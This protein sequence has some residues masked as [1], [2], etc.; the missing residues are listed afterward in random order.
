MAI[1]SSAPSS[2]DAGRIDSVPASATDADEPD[3]VRLRRRAIGAVVAYFLLDGIMRSGYFHFAA[4]AEGFSPPFADA[5][6]S[7]LTGSLATVLVFFGIVVPMSRRF[8]V[9]GPGWQRRLLPHFGALVAFSLSKTVLMWVQRSLLW[10]AVGLGRYDYG[11]LAYRFPMEAANDVT[12]Y[13]LLTIAVHIW[14]AWVER[15][16]RELRRA[17][18]EA[19][20]SEARLAALQSQLQP[21][22]LFNTLNV[23]S[24]VVYQDARKADV[25][26]TRLS[27]LLRASLD[28]PS[29]PEV[30]LE[31][32][33]AILERYVELMEARFGD[34]L[35]VRVRAEGEV[36]GASVPVFLLQPLVENAI[37]YAVAPSARQGEVRVRVSRVG[38]ELRIVVDD[39]GP[40][41]PGDPERAVGSGVGLGNLR[42]RLVHLYDG[43]ARLSL[44]NRPDGGL[45]VDVRLPWHT[46]RPDRTSE[47]TG[48]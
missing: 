42:D 32:E 27:E 19:R 5:L 40:G 35:A 13:A 33:L 8:P 10:P 46:T 18:L 24:S 12:G 31:E 3:E 38:S 36:R 29:R 9:R 45:R 39:D 37:Q 43:Q 26:I 48:A 14:D 17:R 22:F 41:I 23:I 11:D 16:A 20:M 34:R 47:A 25:L 6:F 2:S 4:R 7:E 44:Q 15:R 30:E 28:A 21:H 1:A